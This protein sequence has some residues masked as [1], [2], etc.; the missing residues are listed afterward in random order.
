MVVA[1]TA[2]VVMV[3]FSLVGAIPFWTIISYAIIEAG[4]L[5]SEKVVS[6]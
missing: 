6:L 3:F 4:N 2:G 1:I 5:V